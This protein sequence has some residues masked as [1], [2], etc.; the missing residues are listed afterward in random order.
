MAAEFVQQ[1]VR[2]AYVAVVVTDL[3]G[4]AGRFQPSRL[5]A[6]VLGRD[7]VDA[8]RLV[9]AVVDRD[10]FGQ[11][12]VA[13]GR[14][15]L[16]HLQQRGLEVERVALHVHALPLLA[17]ALVGLLL[18]GGGVDDRHALAICVQHVLL[19]AL[20][21]PP[22]VARVDLPVG[23]DDV[24]VGVAVVPVVVDGVGAC[25]STPGDLLVDEAFH[26]L[27]AQLRAELARQRNHYLLGRAGVHLLFGHLDRVEQPLRV[28]VLGRRPLG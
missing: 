6:F 8:A 21:L 4:D 1:T 12:L 9:A 24:G 16:A 7:A 20:G 25:V 28:G 15:D 13:G 26:G 10:A 3:G 19:L 18:S 5:V 2:A 11:Q 22:A 27:A 17:V 23:D 14:P